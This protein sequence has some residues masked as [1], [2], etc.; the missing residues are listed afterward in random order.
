MTTV[1]F[2]RHAKPNF[3]NHDDLTRELSQQG[4]E[5][6]KFVTEY[7]QDKDIDVVL[8]SPFKRAVD[9]VKD[10]ADAKGLEVIT[11]SDFRERRVDSGWI[12]DFNSFCE[13]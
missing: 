10:F 8:S 4:L 13:I 3:D 2:V 12:E 9:T 6:R 7:L 11:V 1:Y 5:D